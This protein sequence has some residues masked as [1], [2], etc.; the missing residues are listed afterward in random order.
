MFEIIGMIVLQ[1]L[2]TVVGVLLGSVSLILVYLLTRRVPA[3]RTRRVARMTAF[4]FP[5]VAM[6]YLEAGFVAHDIFRM[7]SGEDSFLDGLFHYPLANGYQ[8]VFFTETGPEGGY[9]QLPGGTIYGGGTLPG[10]TQIHGVQVTRGY[11]FIHAEAEPKGSGIKPT[12]TVTHGAV[13][14]AP[15]P[16]P[17]DRYIEID[18][19]TSAV[20]DHATLEDLRMAAER[21]G[22]SLQLKS[23]ADAYEEALSAARPGWAFLGVLFAPLV[24]ATAWLLR[25]LHKLRRTASS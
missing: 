12:V 11:L 7:V 25:K 9:I 18:T 17:V 2:L 22:A 23:A 5:V 15:A 14:P 19:R 8:Y 10:V 24:A 4:L 13:P 21:R 3:S 1:V 20:V 6:F 16:K